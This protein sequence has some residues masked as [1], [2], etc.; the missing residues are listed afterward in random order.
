MEAVFVVFSCFHTASG[1][2]AT[3]HCNVTHA[4]IADVLNLG[5]MKREIPFAAIVTFRVVGKDEWSL[6]CSN[7]SAAD[8][9]D[10]DCVVEVDDDIGITFSCR[11]HF[12]GF[13]HRVAQ[14]WRYPNLSAVFRLWLQSS[15]A[16]SS[17]ISERLSLPAE[18]ARVTPNPVDAE[19]GPRRAQRI[20]R[21]N[22]RRTRNLTGP[23]LLSFVAFLLGKLIR[24]GRTHV[25]D[26]FHFA[27]SKPQVVG[28]RL[29]QAERSVGT[30]AVFVRVAI[31]LPI[32]FPEA[33]LAN[34]ESRSLA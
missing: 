23:L 26:H 6:L 16:S 18:A 29:S 7:L 4:A 15:H 22:P 28:S 12:K 25:L 34:L 24:T 19:C 30:T 2:R 1:Q 8:C 13:T 27:R 14:V 31:V 3:V 5:S 33:D 17:S 10:L 20:V 11:D 21:R 9:A 32:V